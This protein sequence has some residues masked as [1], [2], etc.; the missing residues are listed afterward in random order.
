RILCGEEDLKTVQTFASSVQIDTTDQLSCYC[1]T[2]PLGND[3]YY[4]DRSLFF[5]LGHFWGFLQ[6]NPAE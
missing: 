5:I 2:W 4:D 1:S 3:Q 6:L